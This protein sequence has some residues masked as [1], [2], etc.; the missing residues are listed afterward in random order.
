GSGAPLPGVH[1]LALTAAD[2]TLA[3]GVI[4]DA[5]GEYALDL[6]PGDYRLQ[7]VDAAGAHPMEWFD[8][9]PMTEIGDAA[10]VSAP[11]VADADLAPS[12]GSIS[13]TVTD[14]PSGD[15][16]AGAFV[17]VIG[18]DGPAGGAVSAADGSYTI[19]ALVA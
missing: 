10:I 19:G 5:N 18:P 13:G 8:D 4:T 3:R 6:A 2:Y 17:M 15:P 9:V 11:G 16:L 1:V 12:R 7:F 14:A